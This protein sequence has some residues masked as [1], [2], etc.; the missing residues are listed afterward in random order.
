MCASSPSGR[1]RK[2]STEG[3]VA[4]RVVRAVETEEEVAVRSFGS[5]LRY[6]CGLAR[7]F[8]DQE[9]EM[10]YDIREME[11]HWNQ[12]WT[13]MDTLDDCDWTA[14]L[15]PPDPPPESLLLSLWSEEPV[16]FGANVSYVCQT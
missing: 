5:V 13:P 12:T 1:R 10:H 2:R 8:L 7:R 4:N 14:C 16:E 11:C 9:T 3:R 15:Y 6:Q